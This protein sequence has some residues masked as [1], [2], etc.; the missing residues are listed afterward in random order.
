MILSLRLGC[1]RDRGAAG[2]LGFVLPVVPR[3][4]LCGCSLPVV[5]KRHQSRV[6]LLKPKTIPRIDARAV[7]GSPH[8]ALDPIPLADGFDAFYPHK[9]KLVRR[10]QFIDAFFD[11]VELFEILLALGFGGFFFLSVPALPTEQISFFV[12][13]DQSCPFRYQSP[14]ST[15]SK[16]CMGP[17][18]HI[19]LGCRTCGGHE[20]WKRR[21]WGPV[22][23]ACISAAGGGR[24]SSAEGGSTDTSRTAEV[25][26][27]NGDDRR[28]REL[29]DAL[30]PEDSDPGVLRIELAMAARAGSST[31]FA[32]AAESLGSRPHWKGHIEAERRRMARRRVLSY[33]AGLGLGLYAL[34]MAVF[35]WGGGQ[36]LI[37]VSKAELVWL[38]ASAVAVGEAWWASPRHGVLGLFG[39]AGASSLV[40]GLDATRR[41]VNPSGR[42]RLFLV[43]LATLGLLGLGIATLSHMRG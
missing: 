12:G 25:Y 8:L 21:V 26:L 22:L 18:D 42:A 17:F 37:R 36:E 33:V 31:R 5:L 27:L 34:A 39:V 9:V 32:R 15:A 28:V 30:R 19:R 2:D 7:V 38:L 20:G 29:L 41:R 13:A 6:E 23:F 11:G 43:T 16:V 24:A 1:C 3:F 10:A 35:A 40:H 4:A 14:C